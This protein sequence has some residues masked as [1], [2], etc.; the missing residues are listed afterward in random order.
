MTP[1]FDCIVKPD[2]LSNR[3][4]PKYLFEGVFGSKNPSGHLLRQLGAASR[5]ANRC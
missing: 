3:N 2:S 1:H 5:G 4:S